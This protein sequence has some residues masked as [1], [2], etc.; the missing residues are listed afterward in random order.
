MV[1]AS[2]I[3]AHTRLQ[4]EVDEAL[5]GAMDSFEDGCDWRITRTLLSAATSVQIRESGPFRWCI[6]V[7]MC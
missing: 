1:G 6:L 2:L 7:G 4:H 3:L 5:L